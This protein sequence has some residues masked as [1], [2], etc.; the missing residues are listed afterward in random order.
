MKPLL[1]VKTGDTMPYLRRRRNDF[2]DW[3]IDGFDGTINDIVVAAPHRGDALPAPAETSGV[4]ITGSHAMVTDHEKWSEQ[5]AAWIPGVIASEVPLLGI[6]Y[7]HQLLAHALGGSIYASPTGIEIGTVEV[8]FQSEAAADPLLKN[9]PSR[10][11]VHASHT[12][13]VARLPQNAVLLASND[14]EP[15]HAFVVGKTAW[16]LQFH[17]EFDA[18]IMRTYIDEF[19]ESIRS[20]GQNPEALKQSVQ[21]TP[22]SRFI[23]KRFAEIVI[24]K[25]LR[26]DGWK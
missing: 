3:V 5:T 15:H 26:H 20:N 1:I 16:G 8:A 12:Q 19:A 14:N 22:Y 10:I 13:S 23:L 24:E 25:S 4:V 2:E 11:K 7:G 9:L 6:C 21:E 17:P 18:E